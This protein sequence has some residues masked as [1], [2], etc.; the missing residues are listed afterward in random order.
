MALVLKS[1]SRSKLEETCEELLQLAQK[2]A[3]KIRSM[4]NHITFLSENA[5]KWSKKFRDPRYRVPDKIIK[6]MER[7]T[8]EY[9]ERTQ[10]EL[11][12][13]RT[14]KAELVSRLIRYKAGA[15]DIFGDPKG[16]AGVSYDLAGSHAESEISEKDRKVVDQEIKLIE[17]V[18]QLGISAIPMPAENKSNDDI[19]L[20]TDSDV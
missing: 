14:Q 15:D 9:K 16:I 10:A 4:H 1:L 5:R 18:L 3:K 6:E 13:L 20:D 7:E 8:E 19:D 17:R 11:I 12:R 2:R